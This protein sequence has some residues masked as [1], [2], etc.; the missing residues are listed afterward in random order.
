MTWNNLN[1][2]KKQK[3]DLWLRP[4][5]LT[6]SYNLDL[7]PVGSCKSETLKKLK[8]SP[9]QI[10]FKIGSIKNSAIFTGKHMCWGL[11]LIKVAE[12]LQRL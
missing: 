5:S 1:Q 8:S 9:L 12:G 3:L 4:W 2:R 7:K 10:I 6:P 11:F